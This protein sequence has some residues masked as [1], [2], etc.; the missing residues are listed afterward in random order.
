[1]IELLSTK[2]LSEELKVIIK[3][4]NFN[5]TEYDAINIHPISFNCRN[6]LK[7]VI[8]SSQSSAKIIL[9]KKIEIE[10]FYC[11][12]NKT[13]KLL[14]ENGQKVA[15]SAK[16]AKNLAHFI[17]KNAK[18]EQFLFFCGNRKREELP[19]ILNKNLVKFKEIEV[20]KTDFNIVSFNS[21]FDAYMFFSPSGIE[22]FKIKNTIENSVVFT[23]GSTTSFEAKKITKKIIT[24]NVPSVEEVVSNVIKYFKK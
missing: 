3:K 2:K 15:K 12:G 21:K 13:K 16:N 1:M 9:R 8:I 23:I 5:L 4:N 7:N 14:L 18:N 24:S 6:K 20:Y 19:M 10:N 22:S 17:V 11:V